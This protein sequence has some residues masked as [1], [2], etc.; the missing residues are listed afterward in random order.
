VPDEAGRREI[1]TVHTEGRPLA[2]DVDLDQLARET[3]GY[4]G[5][6]I[7]AVCR[8]AATAAVR[9]H[10]ATGGPVEEITLTAADF[11]QALDEVDASEDGDG[12]FDDFEERI[13]RRDGG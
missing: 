13:E 1:F 3:D 6:D 12:R 8:E 5:A 2:D 7:E 10:V 4:V 11:E 9:S